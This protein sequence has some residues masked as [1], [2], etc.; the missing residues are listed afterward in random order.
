MKIA[1][2]RCW[3]GFGLSEAVFDE[4]GIKWTGYG[5]LENENFPSISKSEEDYNAWRAH[6]DL[7]AAI[8]AVGLDKASASMSEVVIVDIPDDIEWE[9][10]DYDG[11]ESIHEVHRSW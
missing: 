3:G 10:Q 8:E 11:Q 4:L 1:I 7:I 6:P 5:Y 9:L 2:N